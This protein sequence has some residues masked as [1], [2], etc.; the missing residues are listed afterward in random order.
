MTAR[1][2]V[3][4]PC[5]LNQTPCSDNLAVSAVLLD[6]YFNLFEGAL[7]A[8]EQGVPSLTLHVA[9]KILARNCFS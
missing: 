2:K 3:H 7:P 4:T 6:N 9:Q 8:A 5:G 1:E